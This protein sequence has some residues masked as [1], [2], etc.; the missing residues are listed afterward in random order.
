M[1][2][3]AF[4]LMHNPLQHYDWGS[5]DSLSRL[6]SLPNPSGEPQ[7]ELWMGA[8]PNGCSQLVTPEG[9]VRLDTWIAAAPARALGADTA[10]RYGRLPYLFKVL[11]AEKALS[12]QVHPS[13]AQAEA[14]FARDNAAGLAATA[15]NRNYR[16]DNHKPELVFALTPYQAMNAFRPIPEIQALFAR[17]A[18]PQ[19]TPLTAALAAQPD[20]AG[21]AAFFRALLT[22]SGD[23]KTRA[24]QALLDAA[25]RWQDEETFAVISSLAQQYPGDVGLFAPLLLHVLTLQPGEAMYLDACTP[26]AYIR[27]TGLEIMAS[28]DNVLRAGLT[29]KHIDVDELLHCTLCR[30][31]DASSLKLTPQ[32][33]GKICHYPV[34]VPDFTFSVYPAGAHALAS[35]GAEILFA[36]D[37]PLTLSDNADQS[38]TLQPGQSAF[39]PASTRHYQVS[40]MGRFARAGNQP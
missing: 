31:R 15:P 10:A 18:I 20:E 11:A 14:G 13:K 21:L 37:G 24:L 27:G 16:D 17:V 26:H 4:F 12:V 38:L 35:Q 8:H 1:S 19:L 29:P 40:A 33:D 3:P 7:A 28:S 36:I 9:E 22:L 25:Q 23:T 34:P 30:G 5:R 2:Q 39:I 6:F 32:R